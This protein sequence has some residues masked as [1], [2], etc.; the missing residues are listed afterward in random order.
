[1]TS[2]SRLLLKHVDLEIEFGNQIVQ[3]NS[4]EE[5]YKIVKE[6]R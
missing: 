4:G 2:K 5:R 1:M 3:I 6:N